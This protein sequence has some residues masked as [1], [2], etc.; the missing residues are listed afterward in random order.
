MD[1]ITGGR[2]AWN[3]VTSYNNTAAKAMG[4]DKVTPHDKRYTEAEEYM[5]MM[6]A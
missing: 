5:E 2:V 6:Y 4:G 1:H 3:V